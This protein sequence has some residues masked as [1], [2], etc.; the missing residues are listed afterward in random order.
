MHSHKQKLADVF[1]RW[2]RRDFFRKSGLLALFSAA[3]AGS[4]C[5]AQPKPRVPLFTYDD[6]GVRP[7]I[8]CMGTLSY[9]SGF[10]VP[11]EVRKVM[12]YASRYCVP[13]HELQAAVGERIAKVMGAEAAIVTTGASGGLTLAAAGIVS[14]GNPEIMYRLPDCTGLKNEFIM[15][16]NQ[17]NNYDQAIRAVGLKVI[18]VES[19][20][21]MEAAVNERTALILTLSPL[22][23]PCDVPM[24]DMIR[25]SKAKKIPL[26]CDA[27][28]DFLVAPDPYLQ[29]GFDL[30]T[31]SGGKPMFGPQSS[32]I[33]IG[34]KNLIRAAY[35]N[36][37]PNHSIGRALKVSKEEIMAML[38]CVELWFN[39]RDHEAEFKTWNGYAQL[40]SDKVT[41]VP[42]VATD[43]KPFDSPKVSPHMTITWDQ[44]KVKVTPQQVHK[45]LDE[46]EPRIKM[47]TTAGGMYI[48]PYTLQEGQAEQVAVRLHE[49]LSSYAV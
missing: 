47:N 23:K 7:F 12:D 31:Y 38:T 46:G 42:T 40:I 13:I 6:L 35:V 19:A 5:T 20:G 34:K 9:Y 49:I 21:E 10:I 26:I 27:A 30:V 32:G 4:T 18:E 22:R 48:R 14:G 2:S 16:K 41:T 36:G 37:A 44:S 25:I 3:G 24:E 11:P 8:N 45:E 17:R 33:L 29:A 43:T 15:P 39:G 28:P 1:G